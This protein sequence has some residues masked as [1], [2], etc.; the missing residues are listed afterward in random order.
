MPFALERCA[1]HDVSNRRSFEAPAA[2]Q[3]AE[4][5]ERAVDRLRVERSDLGKPFHSPIMQ[6]ACGVAIT[7]ETQAVARPG[8]KGRLDLR[9]HFR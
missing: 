6:L 1:R 9:A 3:R 2:N 4:F 5:L 7:E 8:A